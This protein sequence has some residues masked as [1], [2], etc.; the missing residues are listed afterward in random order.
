MTPIFL[1][2]DNPRWTP[3]TEADL[4]AAI[5]D[6]L[7]G[8]TH[9]LDAK[10]VPSSKGENKET[11]RDLA[12]FAIDSGTVIIGIAED[13]PNRTF[14]LAPQPLDGLAEKI[15]Q[16]ARFNTDP[17]LH[18]LTTEIPTDADTNRGYLI[19]H[20]PAS[21][22]APHMVDGRY[23]GRGDK[24][25]YV[26]PDP[27][28]LRLHERRR[29][30]DRDALALLQHEID[31]DP[32]P[33]DQRSQAHLFLIAQPLA[34][35]R[36]MLLDLIGGPRWNQNLAGF[37]D[38]AFTPELNL[39]LQGT[40]IPPTLKMA[41]TGFRRARSV[42]RATSNLGDGR[43]F[44]AGSGTSPESAI[45]LR[46]HEDGGLRLF[47]SRLSDILQGINGLEDQQVIMD[48]AAVNCTRRFLALALAAAETAGYF[49]NWA[50]AFGATGLRGMPAHG[51][52]L[53]FASRARYD[54]DSYTETTSVSWAELDNRPGAV[55]RRLIGPF[56][57][58][59]DAEQDYAAI[60][61][62][63]AS[64]PT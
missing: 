38:R 17:P 47:F 7:L 2:A 15:E 22:A 9:Y 37:V 3:K 31:N 59:F 12:S 44:R 28:V 25:K 43:I 57:R 55:T 42:A 33:A 16:V 1:S 64:P 40:D 13:K 49:G 27:E 62:D 39:V 24:T 58:T 54:E 4:Q 8:E 21:P 63:P 61:N 20:I 35:R 30:A 46:V 45:E 18:I 34:G 19:V 29:N 5:D 32:I 23:Y 48:A 26:L 10:E 50:V 53:G 14:T 51:M 41:G 6:G 36:D 11:A 60:L 56:L 52:T